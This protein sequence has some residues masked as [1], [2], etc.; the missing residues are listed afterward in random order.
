MAAAVAIASGKRG[1]TTASSAAP[2]AWSDNPDQEVLEQTRV[3]KDGHAVTRLQHFP[4][5]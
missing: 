2:L 5:E 4:K 3:G 1:S